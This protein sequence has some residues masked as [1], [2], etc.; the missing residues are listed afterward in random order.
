MWIAR[1]LE[2]RNLMQRCCREHR[3]E[4]PQRMRQCFISKS[5]AETFRN[6][7]NELLPN[8][9]NVLIPNRE[10]F[11]AMDFS[12]VKVRYWVISHKISSLLLLNIIS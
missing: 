7:N 3:I 12:V 8:E 10:E 5:F 1:E 2:N 11:E 9:M 4:E 6:L